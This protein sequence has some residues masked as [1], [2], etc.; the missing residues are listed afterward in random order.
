M[1]SMERYTPNNK[2]FLPLKI[3]LQGTLMVCLTLTLLTYCKEHENYFSFT[4]LSL[5]I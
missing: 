4:Y 2:Q 5:I 3:G 1:K